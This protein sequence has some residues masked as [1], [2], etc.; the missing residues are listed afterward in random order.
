[1][2]INS[3]ERYSYVKRR[4]NALNTINKNLSD[5][6]NRTLFKKFVNHYL[7]EDGVLALRLLSRNSQDLIVSEIINNLYEL[8]RKQQRQQ[9]IQLSKKLK[10]GNVADD[11]VSEKNGLVT[12]SSKCST[13]SE[14][15]GTSPN[16]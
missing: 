13:V 16:V 14:T 10:E 2:I 7:K 11:Q 4:L 9:L 3:H 5:S 12:K 6:E 1:L 8:Y 15:V